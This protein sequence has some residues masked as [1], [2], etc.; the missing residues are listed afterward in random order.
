MFA[1]NGSGAT[2][3]PASGSF[4]PLPPL[5]ADEPPVTL[6]PELPA[7]ELPPAFPAPP[8]ARLP[9]FPACPVAP[10][11]ALP[12]L[13]ALPDA[14][15]APPAG[16]PPFPVPEWPRLESDEPQA[17]SKLMTGRAEAMREREVM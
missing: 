15:T 14:F 12:P 11:A 8:F 13:G 2:M 17:N 1:L 16:V 5:D 6:P 9:P 3:G 7:P 4:P 10:A